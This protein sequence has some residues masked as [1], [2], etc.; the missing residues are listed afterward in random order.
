VLSTL[1]DI[2]VPES[3][4]M[5]YCDSITCDYNCDIMLNP[6]PKYRE[7]KKNET[8]SNIYNFNRH[9]VWRGLEHGKAED[10]KTLISQKTW[11]RKV[12]EKFILLQYTTYL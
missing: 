4:T 6:N 9:V 5:F 11:K 1:Y 2:I 3:S 12:L 8:R 10:Y 7:T